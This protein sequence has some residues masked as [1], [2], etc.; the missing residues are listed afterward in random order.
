MKYF[1]FKNKLGLAAILRFS[2]GCLLCRHLE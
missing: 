2:V 1:I